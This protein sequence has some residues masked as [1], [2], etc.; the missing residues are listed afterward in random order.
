METTIKIVISTDYYSGLS[1]MKYEDDINYLANELDVFAEISNNDYT[2]II[3]E[4]KRYSSSKEDYNGSVL[5]ESTGYSQGEWQRTKI[6][7][8]KEDDNIQ[9]LEQLTTLIS[10]MFTHRNDYSVVKKEVIHHNGREY[11]T[12]IDHATFSINHIEFPEEEDII[13]EYD[14]TY[15]GNYDDYEL[16]TD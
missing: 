12:D 13:R 4:Q 1:D 7:Y 11:E 9:L 5:V 10:R 2:N 15:G 8:N 16:H 3:E 14:E 6:Y